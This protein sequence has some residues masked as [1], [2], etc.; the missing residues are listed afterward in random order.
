MNLNIGT[1]IRKLR[2]EREMTQEE[3]AEKL[4]VSFQAVSKWECGTTTPDIATLP[5]IALFFGISMDALFS[6][7]SDDYLE[8]ISV[9]LR[10]E[11]TISTENFIWAE[12]YLKGVLT[13]DHTDNRVRA[14]LIELYAHRENRDSLTRG[15]LA[16]EGILLEP[17]NVDLNANLM[18]VREKRGE[19]DRL[20]AFWEPLLEKDA[21]NYVIREN[22][23]SVCIRNRYFDKAMALIKAAPSARPVYD[24]FLGDIALSEGDETSAKKIWR[25]TAEK[26]DDAWTFYQAGERFEKVCEYNTAIELWEKSYEKSSAPKWMDSLYSRAFLYEKLNQP[27]LAIRMW[28]QIIAALAEDYDIRNGETVDWA[29]REIERLKA[30]S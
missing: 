4:S 16:E 28:E 26:S 14:L 6:M 10:D 18:R 1:V 15:R 9:M 11:H 20:I 8:R 21:R 25:D 3:L 13:E 12:R 27:N 23:I 22:L 24:L 19:F 5:R 29:R 30:F 7:E 2:V 17:M